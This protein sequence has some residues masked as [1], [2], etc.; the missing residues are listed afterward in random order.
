M[1]YAAHSC[2][3]VLPPQPVRR[4]E[5]FPIPRCCCRRAIFRGRLRSHRRWPRA[6]PTPTIPRGHRPASP[7]CMKPLLS[8][9]CRALLRLR[10][11]RPRRCRAQPNA[12]VSRYLCTPQPASPALLKRRQRRWWKR[13]WSRQQR[14]RRK[15]GLMPALPHACGAPRQSARLRALARSPR[16]GGRGPSRSARD[17]LRSCGVHVA[18]SRG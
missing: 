18:R 16:A 13:R 11:R 10:R 8:P 4:C 12:T 7:R 17:R 9:L 3:A 15:P 1:L 2:I 6:Q 5:P 14:R